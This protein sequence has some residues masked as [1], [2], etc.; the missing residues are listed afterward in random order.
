MTNKKESTYVITHCIFCG[1]NK[2]PNID[3]VIKHMH[4]DCPENK[5]D[6]EA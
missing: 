6:R 2:F 3:E 1:Q 5:K 4:T